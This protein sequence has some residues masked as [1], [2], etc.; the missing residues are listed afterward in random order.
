MNIQYS[1]KDFH[2]KEAY[3]ACSFLHLTSGAS[4]VNGKMRKSSVLN[5]L[6]SNQYQS[7]QNIEEV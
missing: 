4:V 6:L 1:Q 7:F 5:D 3:R 2:V